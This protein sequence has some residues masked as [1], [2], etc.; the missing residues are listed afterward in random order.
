MA[1][2]HFR[3]EEVAEWLPKRRAVETRVPHL[4]NDIKTLVK[5]RSEQKRGAER[6]GGGIKK[7]RRG[8]EEKREKKEKEMKKGV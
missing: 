7:E 4:H 2:K 8:K 5:Q 6:A 1:G 3:Y